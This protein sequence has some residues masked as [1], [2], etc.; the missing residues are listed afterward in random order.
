MLVTDLDVIIALTRIISEVTGI[1]IDEID[2]DK[3]F[4]EDLDIDSLSMVEIAVAAQD[5]FNLDIPDDRLKHLK[6]VRDV[7]G[8]ILG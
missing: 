4:A 6:T 3:T 1:P 5:E 2:P 7:A 8:F